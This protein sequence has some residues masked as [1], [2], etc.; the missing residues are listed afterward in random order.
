LRPEELRERFA[1]YADH[2][3]LEHESAAL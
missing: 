3:G 2:F 1:F